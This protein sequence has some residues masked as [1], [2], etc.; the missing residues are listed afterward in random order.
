MLAQADLEAKK[1]IKEA[2]MMAAEA[3]TKNAI[4]YKKKL[5]AEADEWMAKN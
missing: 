4:A 1:K 5:Q 2:A 3:Q